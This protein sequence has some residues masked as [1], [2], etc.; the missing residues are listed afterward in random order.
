MCM[1]NKQ[2]GSRYEMNS[3]NGMNWWPGEINGTR[4]F[5]G[6]LSSEQVASL[7]KVMPS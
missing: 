1:L 4:F 7:A 2:V 6:A 5:A 3:D